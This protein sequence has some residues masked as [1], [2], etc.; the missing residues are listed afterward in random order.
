MIDRWLKKTSVHEAAAELRKTPKKEACERF[1]KAYSTSGPPLASPE[2]ADA[3]ILLRTL[4]ARQGSELTVVSWNVQLMNKLDGPNDS[5]I[6]QAVEDKAERISRVVA[7]PRAGGGG[8]PASLLVIQEA[9]GPQ[10]RDTGGENARRGKCSEQ[11]ARRC[12][13]S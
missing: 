7:E 6:A 11:K 8:R 9:P 13:R 10:L 1:L 2:D 5:E 3:G 4:W 12:R